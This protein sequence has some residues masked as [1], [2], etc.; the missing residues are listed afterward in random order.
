MDMLKIFPQS[1][2]TDYDT[3][4]EG[5]EEACEG[6]QDGAIVEMAS[7]YVKGTVPEQSRKFAPPPPEF[8]H[9]AKKIDAEYD[10]HEKRSL[11]VQRN[12]NIKAMLEN[13]SRRIEYRKTEESKARVKAML[14]KA[15]TGSF[16]KL[17]GK[18]IE[19]TRENVDRYN[20]ERAEF[21][22]RFQRMKIERAQGRG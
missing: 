1:V 20:K 4:M 22:E 2:V 8:A 14:K 7:R 19:Q 12:R 3:M 16:P 11:E 18:T 5:Y 9:E 10:G 15:G 21:K 17:Q 6:I 13:N